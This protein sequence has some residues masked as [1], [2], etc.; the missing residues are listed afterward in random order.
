MNS[1]KL[2][3]HLGG[4]N[5]SEWSFCRREAVSD[6]RVF[7]TF[8]ETFKH[9]DGRCGDF[10]INESA[11]WVQTAAILSGSDIFNPRVVL[12]NQFRFGVKRSSWEFPGGIIE[13]GESPEKAAARELME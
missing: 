6:C 9:P 8:K 12:V 2:G 10:F 13:S 1:E 7:K 4:K 11:D 5:P 3:E